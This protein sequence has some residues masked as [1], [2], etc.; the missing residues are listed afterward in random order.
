[1]EQNKSKT[2]GVILESF[3]EKTSPRIWMKEAEGDAYSL[4]SFDS[5]ESFPFN[6]TT[7]KE[8]IE[9]SVKSALFVRTGLLSEGK[10][11][12]LRLYSISEA[13]RAARNSCNFSDALVIEMAAK[14]L[15]RL[16]FCTG[17]D[18][19]IPLSEGRTLLVERQLTLTAKIIL[20]AIGAWLAGKFIKLK[21]RGSKN[22]AT[23][24]GS[25]LLS[26]KRFQDE[27]KK[28]GASLESVMRLLNAK[29]MD[30]QNFEKIFGFKWPI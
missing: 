2:I 7:L 19:V 11:R 25:A 23:A 12:G 3:G 10:V 29:N 4:P 26:S 15:N 9:P 6:V 17:I 18:D 21:F 24:L 16:G 20:F 27:L 13:W 30:A 1:M 5:N 8:G 14:E 22:Q 28:P